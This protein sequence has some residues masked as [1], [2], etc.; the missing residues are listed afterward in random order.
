MFD[1]RTII[2]AGDTVISDTVE[3]STWASVKALRK[4][5]FK[6]TD[7]WYLKDRWDNLSSTKKGQLNS[8]RESMRDL[9]QNYDDPTEAMSNFPIPEDW[10]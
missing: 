4:I 2:L 5:Y 7:L 6:K 8:F 1:N 3:P 9:P 10:F